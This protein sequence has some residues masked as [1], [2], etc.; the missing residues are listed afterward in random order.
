MVLKCVTEGLDERF[1]VYPFGFF[2]QGDRPIVK[3]S[4]VAVGDLG[5]A[6]R[7]DRVS[8]DPLDGFYAVAGNRPLWVLNNICA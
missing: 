8:P 2:R 5:Q 6:G 1:D 7:L 3:R 4:T